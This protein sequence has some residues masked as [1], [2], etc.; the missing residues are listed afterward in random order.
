MT[1]QLVNNKFSPRQKSK[2]HFLYH[3]RLFANRQ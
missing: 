1:F 2:L 3:S